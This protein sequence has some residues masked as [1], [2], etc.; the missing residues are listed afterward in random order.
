MS[1][2]GAVRRCVRQFASAVDIEEEVIARAELV[3]T[4]LATNLYRH[5]PAGGQILVG[6]PGGKSRC[7]ELVALD[8]GPGIANPAAM[9]KNGVSTA[10]SLGGGLGAVKR[11]SDEFDMLSQVGKGT[12]IS[13]QIQSK[14]VSCGE[15]SGI[16]G[17][18]IG[19][20]CVPITGE[21]EC[22]DNWA[23]RGNDHVVSLVVIDGLGHGPRAAKATSAALKVVLEQQWSNSIHLLHLMDEALVNTAGAAVAVSELNLHTHALK[24]CGVGNISGRVYGGGHVRGC[25]SMP[26][27]VGYKMPKLQEFSFPWNRQS[28]ILLYSDGLS[29]RSFPVAL[30]SMNRSLSIAGELYRDHRRANDDAT[31]LLAKYR[32][33]A[34]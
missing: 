19:A 27:I 22:G 8:N 17:L 12:V 13:C 28:A 6:M 30:P 4:E 20:I 14:V 1:D 33:M 23:A 5:A 29:S 24:F 10:G 15:D 3:S 31:V 9:M 2:V 7:I 34:S 25:V 11:L 26:G 21:S 32:N 18:D 16:D